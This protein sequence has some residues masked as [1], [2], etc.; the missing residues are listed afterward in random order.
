MM[1]SMLMLFAGRRSLPNPRIK[2]R[3]TRLGHVFKKQCRM[4][5]TRLI[6]LMVAAETPRQPEEPRPRRR[7]DLRRCNENV[8]VCH[9]FG[10]VWADLSICT[11]LEKKVAKMANKTHKDR[12]NEFNSK[13]EALSEHHDI[14]KVRF[15][16]RCGEIVSGQAE[17]CV[18]GWTRLMYC[19]FA[20]CALVGFF[21]SISQ[22][23]SCMFRRIYSLF[24]CYMLY[25]TRCG[26]R[27]L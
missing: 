9:K 8:C 21:W 19:I 1:C 13:L 18:L 26:K 25:Y 10:L 27:E 6:R 15:G 24:L 12:V 3:R 17:F 23:L 2:R 20:L 14:P 4:K 22:P 16:D 11:Q 7:R 5:Q